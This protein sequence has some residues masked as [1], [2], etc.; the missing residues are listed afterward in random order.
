MVGM[1]EDVLGGSARK[2]HET[3][4]PD[5]ADPAM[6]HGRT[7]DEGP[8]TDHGH[9]SEYRDTRG[10]PGYKLWARRL[11]S[12]EDYDLSKPRSDLTF[13]QTLMGT[14]KLQAELAKQHLTPID[15]MSAHF[16]AGE[17]SMRRILVAGGL[18][19]KKIAS[20]LDRKKD[21]ERLGR[22]DWSDMDK[23]DS[24]LRGSVVRDGDGRGDKGGDDFQAYPRGPRGDRAVAG[25][26]KTV[27][28][29]LSLAQR[30][31]IAAPPKALPPPPKAL[32]KPDRGQDR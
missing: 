27:V 28:H 29:G 1:G 22:F 23:P 7:R 25:E 11:F 10:T 31:A 5:L 17:E 8:L 20:W 14:H 16:R 15:K 2:R 26:G 21:P 18:A 6:A 19:S 4:R 13:F 9:V 24:V 12:G 32:P 3:L 30:L